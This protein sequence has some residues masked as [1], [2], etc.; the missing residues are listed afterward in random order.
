MKLESFL[1]LFEKVDN[2]ELL[3]IEISKIVVVQ[4]KVRLIEKYSKIL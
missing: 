3:N 4:V 2:E 1:V